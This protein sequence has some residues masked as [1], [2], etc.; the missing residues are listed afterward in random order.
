MLRG[1]LNMLGQAKQV[2]AT[3]TTSSVTF[4][5]APGVRCNS[6]ITEFG[7]A[8]KDFTGLAMSISTEP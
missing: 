6:K 4:T 2:Y 3:A 1:P 8:S 7:I 5:L